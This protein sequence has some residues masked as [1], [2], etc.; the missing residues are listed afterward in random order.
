MPLENKNAQTVCKAFRRVLDQ[1]KQNPKAIQTDRGLEFKNKIFKSL[2]SSRNIKQNFPVTPSPFKASVVE[3]FNRTLKTKIFR[4]FKYTNKKNYRRYVD[5]LPDI[6]Q[7]YNAT[8][9]SS[10]LMKPRDVNA[11][12]APLVYSNIHRRHRRER[13]VYTNQHLQ[14]GEY[15]R[16]A[17]KK[18]PL[19]AGIFKEVW[20]KEFFIVDKIINKIPY[21]LY[22]IRDVN[23]REVDGKF[24]FEQ[25]QKIRL[26]KNTIVKVLKRQGLGKNQNK[27]VLFANGE[28]KW[29][30]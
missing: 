25:L 24:Y 20:S 19:D 16:V 12:N 11:Y 4:Y 1:S 14:K 26:P 5:V 7:N 10:T 21:K 9:H 22:N 15:V 8:V 17:L 3:I 29:V 27:Y 18:R 13:P 28:K 23:E 30:K 2:L 6:L